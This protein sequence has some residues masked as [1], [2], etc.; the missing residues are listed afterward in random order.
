M[1]GFFGTPVSRGW[2]EHCASHF[3]K[4]VPLVL[5]AYCLVFLKAC[6]KRNHMTQFCFHGYRLSILRWLKIIFLQ[7]PETKD[8]VQRAIVLVFDKSAT[9][10]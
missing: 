8:T 9:P 10:K 1:W 3:E 7:N 2:G 5:T 6:P 4:H